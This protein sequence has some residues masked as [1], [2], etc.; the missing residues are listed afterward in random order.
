MISKKKKNVTKVGAL[1]LAGLLAVGSGGLTNQVFA[2]EPDTTIVHS[3]SEQKQVIQ[4]EGVGEIKVLNFKSDYKNFDFDELSEHLKALAEKT[5]TKGREEEKEKV[6]TENPNDEDYVKVI[7]GTE[8]EE[9]ESKE[10]EKEK[11][12]EKSLEKTKIKILNSEN[13][14]L[15]E[16]TLKDFLARNEKDKITW[17]KDDV[18]DGKV[19]LKLETVGNID[20]DSFA[21]NLE[22]SKVLL[23]IVE[24]ED[25][26]HSLSAYILL[27][28]KALTVEDTKSDEVKPE[29]NKDKKTEAGTPSE[30]TKET[31]KTTETNTQIEDADKAKEETDKKA[32]EEKLAKEEAEAEQKVKEEQ[33][34]KDAEAQKKA[35]E[36][37][38]KKDAE[39]KEK[40]EQDAKE[41]ADQEAKEKAEKEAKEKAKKDAEL[42]KKAQ[43]E[44]AKR[45]SEYDT[46]Q[47]ALK[48]QKSDKTFKSKEEAAQAANEALKS[49][50]G[51]GFHSY[52]VDKNADG[53]YFYTLSE[54]KTKVSEKSYKTEDEA[55]K[56]AI[57]ALKNDSMYKSYRT[58]QNSDGSWSYVLS[59][60]LDPSIK[61]LE[62]NKAEKQD[63]SLKTSAVDPSLVGKLGVFGTMI[64]SLL[65]GFVV[66]KKKR[67]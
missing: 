19:F 44:A 25:K 39:A 30:T 45:K 12:D 37:Q 8:K 50:A 10:E 53:S 38:A 5:K 52:S 46:Q 26:S 64:S 67:K 33:A 18:K 63:V 15:F 47:K 14:V 31:E 29:D 55:I 23:K 62:K 51:K 3:K 57:E 43:E 60:Q 27:A 22:A 61:D 21:Y 36:E 2:V 65:G 35:E 28:D 66:Y 42:I 59:D 13:K 6:V 34:R 9:V 41:K 49:D 20:K 54:E 7:F 56:A 32:E 11:F 58:Q 24:N 48:T 16:S 1:A 40:A 4:P 17:K